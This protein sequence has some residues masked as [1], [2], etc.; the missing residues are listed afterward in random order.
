M[1]FLIN[2]MTW[3]QDEEKFL[4]NLEKQCGVYY[5][6]FNKEYI[7]Y[8]KLSSKF[9]IP[10]LIVSAVNSLIAIILVPFVPQKYVSIMNAVLSA[11]TGVVGSVQLYLKVNEKMSNALRSSILMKRL[12]LKISKEISI[13]PENRLSDGQGFLSDSFTEFNAAI[14]QANPIQKELK[15]HLDQTGTKRLWGLLDRV[16]IDVHSRD[17]EPSPPI[18][19]EAVRQAQDS[20][21]STQD[22]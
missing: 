19:V 12:S 13:F 6:H 22:P 21:T 10:I 3:T 5:K 1:L 7:Y 4:E 14:E 16:N 17:P 8:N 11:G 18:Q 9:N 20:E 2:S 15:N